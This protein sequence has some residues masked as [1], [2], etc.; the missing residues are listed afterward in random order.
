MGGPKPCLGYPSRTA[1]IVALRA[2]GKSTH[3]IAAAVGVSRSTVTALEADRRLKRDRQCDP[4]RTS[5]ARTTAAMEAAVMDLHDR[6]HTP[7]QIAEKLGQPLHR[8]RSILYYMREG[9]AEQAFG[10]KAT[11]QSTAALLAAIRRHHPE[12][13]G[14]AA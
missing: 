8:V 13:C 3:E 14:G 7:E 10:P 12:R 6:R 9:Q 5:G 4:Q 2:E 1:A 11:A